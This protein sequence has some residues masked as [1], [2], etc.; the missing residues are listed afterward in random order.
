M[1]NKNTIVPDFEKTVQLYFEVDPQTEFLSSLKNKLINRVRETQQEHAPFNIR[2]VVLAMIATFTAVI[3]VFFRMP[4]YEA[5]GQIFIELFPKTESNIRPNTVYITAIAEETAAAEIDA[6]A[7]PTQ[8]NYNSSPATSPMEATNTQEPEAIEFAFLTIE[9]V[10]NAAGFDVLAPS[11]LPHASPFFGAPVDPET[12]RVMILP[13]WQTVLL[14]AD[15][16]WALD[17]FGAEFDSETNIVNLFYRNM[18]ISQEKITGQH[19]CDLCTPI[20]ANAK[21]ATVFINDVPGQIAIGVWYLVD[22]NQYWKNDP[23]IQRLRWESDSM[24]FE[25]LYS[26]TPGS[27]TYDSMVRIAESMN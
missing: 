21:S 1:D 20:G 22:E 18:K 12:N 2:R 7:T 16:N 24:V 14:P 15:S 10:E 27:L 6:I 9:A 3:I 13:D 8:S 11:L 5:L 17:F 26:Y 4:I 23:W 19:D 25:I